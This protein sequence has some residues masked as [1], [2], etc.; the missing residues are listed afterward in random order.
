MPFLSAMDALY[1]RIINVGEF[2][3]GPEMMR[4]CSFCRIKHFSKDGSAESVPMSVE[5]S[6][7]FSKE[8]STK[9]QVPSTKSWGTP[10]QD[11]LRYVGRDSMFIVALRLKGGFA[12]DFAIIVL[13]IVN[14]QSLSLAYTGHRISFQRLPFPPPTVS[15]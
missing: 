12:I 14:P 3:L 7:S 2:G 11:C 4:L 6:T 5:R 8:E 10:P 9:S 13:L 1:D 15:P